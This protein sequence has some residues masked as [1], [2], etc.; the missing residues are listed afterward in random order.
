MFDFQEDDLVPH[1]NEKMHQHRP[2]QVTNMQPPRDMQNKIVDNYFEEDYLEG[3]RGKSESD[4]GEVMRR[5][6]YQSKQ[7]ERDLLP[8]S[9]RRE[10]RKDGLFSDEDDEQMFSFRQEYEGRGHRMD[11]DDMPTTS[12]KPRR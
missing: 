6:D 3:K 9:G 5:G 1:F 12:K 7:T 11:S 8:T 10:E 4:D 2:S